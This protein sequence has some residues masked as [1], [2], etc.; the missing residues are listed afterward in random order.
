MLDQ[1]YLESVWLLLNQMRQQG[2]VFMESEA[3]LYEQLNKTLLKRVD[4]LDQQLD[5]NIR[6]QDDDR[7]TSDQGGTP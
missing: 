2:K 6:E 5:Q 4:M 7:N 1:Q 3:L